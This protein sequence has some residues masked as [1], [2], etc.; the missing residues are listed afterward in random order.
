[1]NRLI[2]I[3]VVSLAVALTVF[4]CGRYSADQGW[5]TLIDGEN[6]LDN[7]PRA[8]RGRTCATY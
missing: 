6:G 3:V 1:M 5:V 8:C 2:R 7:L 4:G